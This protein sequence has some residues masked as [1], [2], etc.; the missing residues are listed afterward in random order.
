[1]E[2]VILITGSS[3]GLGKFLADYLSKRGFIVFAGM[4]TTGKQANSVVPI[5]LDVTDDVSCQNSL[6]HI[7]KLHQ[8]ID[9]L[10]NCAAMTLVG[11]T[12]SFSSKEFQSILDVNLIGPFRL[13]KSVIPIMKKQRSGRII[14][15]TSLNGKLAFPNFSIYGASKFGLE[16]L[17][18]SLRYELAQTGVFVTNVAPGAIAP[19]NSTENTPKNNRMPHV[20][21]REKFWIMKKLMPMVTM[22]E[23][24]RAIETVITKPNPPSQIEL[25]RDVKVA[26]LLHRLLPGFCWDSLM[27]FVWT[28]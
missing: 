18:L 15:I 16:A 14:N 5:S 21:A 6:D 23:I 12:D 27:T 26:T 13:I 9:V 22:D 19:V 10:I 25:G 20:P 24:A 17:G 2:K 11:P 7:H 8:R 1:M 4:R 3:S 28:R